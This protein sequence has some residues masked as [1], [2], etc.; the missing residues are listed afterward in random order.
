MVAAGCNPFSSLLRTQIQ[1]PCGQKKMLK[2]KKKHHLS[3]LEMAHSMTARDYAHSVGSSS[4]KQSWFKTKQTQKTAPSR[5]YAH[6]NAIEPQ[7]GRFYSYYRWV[8]NSLKLT[9]LLQ[10]T[11]FY[12]LLPWSKIDLPGGKKNP[13]CLPPPSNLYVMPNQHLQR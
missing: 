7:E 1:H 13:N 11:S 8:S 5:C 10:V 4:E 9:A 2:G 6:I 3:P 12:L